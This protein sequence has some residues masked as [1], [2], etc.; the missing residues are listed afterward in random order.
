MSDIT[1]PHDKFFKEIFSYPEVAQDFLLHYLPANIR[2]QLN[3]NTIVLTKESYIDHT[4]REQFSDLLY[5]VQLNSGQDL[6]T[7][8]LFEH[9]SY[10]EPLVAF[11]LLRYMVQIWE[12]DL[13]DHNP[14]PLRWII[15]IVIYHGE[16]EWNIKNEFC[17]LFGDNEEFRSF[18]PNFHFLIYDLPRY[19]DDEIQ[20][21]LLLRIAVFLMKYIY[22]GELHGKLP[23]IFQLLHEWNQK[24]NL[25]EL[26]ETVVKYL[27]NATDR[28]SYDELKESMGKAF[29]DQEGDMMPT[30]AEELKLEGKL[31][32]RIEG[33]I[34]SSQETI[35][36]ILRTRFTHVP[37]CVQEKLVQIHDFDL[38]KILLQ[39]SVTVNSV[40]EFIQILDNEAN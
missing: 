25:R 27:M 26:I 32:G 21:D 37:S 29:Q 10:P 18:I 4:L 38:L 9:K 19:R 7:Y 17:H 24:R 2:D 6:Y 28:I 31:E 35:L 33:K 14:H 22:S 36:E 20:G 1:N 23:L 13:K 8:V 15:P 12:N 30:I 3:P 34:E 39:S 5:L 11:Q 40:N 16:T